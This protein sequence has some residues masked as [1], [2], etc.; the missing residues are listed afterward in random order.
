MD[1]WPNEEM[2]THK[3][4]KYFDLHDF[5]KRSF[6]SSRQAIRCSA[7]AKMSYFSLHIHNFWTAVRGTAL[8]LKLVS[9]ANQGFECCV[10]I[11]WLTLKSI[12]RMNFVTVK[13][14]ELPESLKDTFLWILKKLQHEHPREIHSVHANVSRWQLDMCWKFRLMTVGHELWSHFSKRL[15]HSV[16]NCQIEQTCVWH[17]VFH[18]YVQR[19]FTSQL[20]CSW[21]ENVVHALACSW[22]SRDR[23]WRFKWSA[24]RPHHVHISQN[25]HRPV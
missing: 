24:S 8:E 5:A 9:A 6:M 20:F 4:K 3:T 21:K 22:L 25:G 13:K 7:R 12:S 18:N 16:Q 23:Y 11:R 19:S 17:L 15:A 1:F 14:D 2:L 10:G